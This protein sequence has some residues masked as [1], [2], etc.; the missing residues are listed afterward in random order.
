MTASLIYKV[1]TRPQWEEAETLDVFKGA[2]V[3][4][5]DGF[6][7]FST[8][9]QVEETVAKHFH[10]QKDLLLVSF[11]ATLFGEKLKWEISRGGDRFPHLYDHLDVAHADQIFELQDHT[12]GSH[13]FPE[14]Y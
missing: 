4:I 3:D 12:D 6:I 14:V 9:S 2:P 1:L 7:H 11:E 5:A 10:G 13:R 8:A